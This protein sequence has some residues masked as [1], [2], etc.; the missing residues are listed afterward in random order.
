MEAVSN[1]SSA[2]VEMRCRQGNH[3]LHAVVYS[4]AELPIFIRGHRFVQGG[5]K[6]STTDIRISAKG[7]EGPMMKH[8]IQRTVLASAIALMSLSSW[9]QTCQTKDDVPESVRKMVESAAQQVFDQ[10]GRN[11]M[12]GIRAG[13]MPSL[14]SG[15][16]DIAN[17]IKDHQT[18]FAGQHP[19]LRAMYVLSTGNDPNPSG[20][21]YCGIYGTDDANATNA[22]FNIPGLPPGK[23]AVTIQDV[24]G[25]DAPHALTMIFQD[26]G[27]W[28]LAGFYIRPEEAAGHDGLW[29]FQHA[30]DYKAQGKVHNAWFY[31]VAAWDLMAPATF[32][33]TNLLTK[34][35]QEASIVQP[36][37]VPKNGS[38]VAFSAGGSTWRITEMSV[39][40]GPK[41]LDLT[42]RY[43]VP[44]A[45]DLNATQADARALCNAYL[46]KYPELKDGFT[47]ILAHAVDT[48]G[49]DVVGIVQLR[50]YQANHER[51][52][53][54]TGIAAMDPAIP[55][56]LRP[57]VAPAPAAPAVAANVPATSPTG[58]VPNA[59]TSAVKTS[60]TG[61]PSATGASSAA[62]PPAASGATAANVPAGSVPGNS[63]PPAAVVTGNN[64]SFSLRVQS[65]EVNLPTTVV[66]Q[67]QRLITNL[68]QAD[69]LVYEDGQPQ[70]ITSFRREDVPVSIGI[71]VDNSGSMRDKRDAVS[72]AVVNFV[73]ASNPKDEVF[74]VNFNDWPYL[75][76][77]FT[78]DVNHL[79]TA[80]NRLDS[81]GST[82]LYDAVVAAN[83][84][85]HEGA[86]RTKR[87]LLVVTD[88]Q[89]NMSRA[90]LEEAVRAVQK[91]K[92]TA[93]II[94]TVGILG[95]GDRDKPA[96]RALEALSQQTGGVAFFPQSLGEVDAV[97]QGIA[98]DIRSQYS[99]SYKP[100]NPQTR[101]G[102]RRV[103]VV[104]RSIG[105]E[106]F[107]VRTRT[108]YFAAS[109]D[110]TAAK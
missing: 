7:P 15:F 40:R 97:T 100:T 57:A 54:P 61:A 50:P 91:N 18:V 95:L 71:L 25:T 63:P 60:V 43:S 5:L 79:R 8:L 103:K 33:S 77:D 93:P 64:N 68:A 19:P 34:I 55:L 88:G 76:Q 17:A 87:I 12:A 80:L 36:P 101:G 96:R 65:E 37:D 81:R 35:A 46:T 53:F 105:K 82:A 51:A 13:S 27:G 66:D 90:T 24:G 1:P 85:L 102:Y 11:D 98:H 108:G 44:N 89:D 72:K 56:R 39:V 78:D 16:G 14:Q 109:H 75:D 86:H 3:A 29:Y 10:A 94:Y 70:Q 4:A 41:N 73:K 6:V 21:F 106:E 22:E 49:R 92:D 20:S 74:I 26:S 52:P 59:G 84:H 31:Y 48:S 30:R 47:T 42:L 99:I 107:Q 62:T 32:M 45:G 69:F 2:R 9:S 110:M 23:Y 104:A 58:N 83:S 67:R 38:D 28:K